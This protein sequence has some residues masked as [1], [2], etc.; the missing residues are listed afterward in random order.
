MTRIKK[1]EHIEIDTTTFLLTSYLFELIFSY[2]RKYNT[3]LT[4]N[5]PRVYS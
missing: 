4:G 1:F 2:L 3:P 5:S